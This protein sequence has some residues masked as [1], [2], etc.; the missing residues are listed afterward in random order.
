MLAALHAARS[1][2]LDHEQRQERAVITHL[3]ARNTTPNV[4]DVLLRPARA[5][6]HAS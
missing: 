1:D 6:P 5:S 4:E 2:R 3:D